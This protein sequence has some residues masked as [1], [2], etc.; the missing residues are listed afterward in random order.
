MDNLVLFSSYPFEWSFYK[1]GMDEK[2]IV[3]VTVSSKGQVDKTEE[4]IL[5]S[6]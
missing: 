4:I 5:N 6:K 1:L 3:K 2:A